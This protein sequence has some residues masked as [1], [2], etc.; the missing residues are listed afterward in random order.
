MNP[1]PSKEVRRGTRLR[2]RAPGEHWELDFTEVSPGTFRFKYLLVFTDTFSG[3]IEAFL[4]KQETAQVVA[5]K[6]V[7]EIVPRFGL[8]ITLGSDNGPAFIAQTS[9]SLAKVLGINW[10]LHCIY[11]PQSSGQVERMNRTLKETLTKFKPETGENW[12]SLLP[13]ALLRAWCTPYC[14]GITPYEI[15]FGRLL[16]S[17]PQVRG[18]KANR[19]S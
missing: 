4:T 7:S 14:K 17:P 6:L 13:F 3:W 15:M 12:V 16:S 8:P 9:Q 18:R 10:K 19:S 5:K 1:G 2:G 11:R